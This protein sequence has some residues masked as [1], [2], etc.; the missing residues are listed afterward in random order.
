[1]IQLMA[2]FWKFLRRASCLVGWP[3][4]RLPS[5][6]GCTMVLTGPPM[7]PVEGV[8]A[9]E[10][11]LRQ[12]AAAPLERLAA[13]GVVIAARIDRPGPDGPEFCALLHLVPVRDRAAATEVR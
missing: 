6:A 8:T 2:R 10:A 3:R 12:G 4:R 13:R 7:P 1:M 9:L 5:A 11:Q